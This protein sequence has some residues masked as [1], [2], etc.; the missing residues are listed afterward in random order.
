MIKV[1]DSTIRDEIIECTGN[2]VISASA[3]TG[4]THITVER[5]KRDLEYNDTYQTFAAITF[6]NKAAKEIKERL[7][8]E[9]NGFVGT[10]DKFIMNEVIKPFASDIFP[11]LKSITINSDYTSKSKFNT[12]NQLKDLLLNKGIV[13]TLLDKKQNY[14]F[15]LALYIIKNSHVASRYIKCKYFRIYIDEYQD[16]DK[17]MHDFFKYLYSV[18]EI[19][20]F[21]VGDKKQSIYEWR[22]GYPEGFQEFIDSKDFNSFELMHNFRSNKQIQNYGNIFVQSIRKNY[23]KAKITNEVI[24]LKYSA[25]DS[26][27]N[28]INDWLDKESTCAFLMFSNSDAKTMASILH[29]FNF[30]YIPKAPLDDPSLDNNQ[31]WVT[32]AVACYLLKKRYNEYS[33]YDEIPKQEQFD[34]IYIKKILLTIKIFYKNKHFNGDFD[35][36]IEKLYKHILSDYND[37][38]FRAEV[39]ALK[40]TLLNDEYKISYNS[41]EYKRIVTTI[42]STKG[43][44][45]NQVII[46][47]DDY[48]NRNNELEEQLHYV[49]VTRPKDK[50]LIILNNSKRSQI[51]LE[52]LNRAIIDTN[53]KITKLVMNDVISIENL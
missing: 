37:E 24:G 34:F 31:I 2:I 19:P 35:K 51:Y 47:A 22:G 50:L 12:E 43:L 3:G 48:I 7:G 36:Y 5:I 18:L 38:S 33:F 6:T 4:K 49:A 23:R 41:E 20:L 39:N 53:T 40:E 16:S 13:G 1:Q 29:S 44:Q 46:N 14:A 52:I 11:E 30:I 21:V 17:D 32:R 10:N 26:L 8:K 28:Y 9:N 42:H 25:M 45:Y 15:K 27:L